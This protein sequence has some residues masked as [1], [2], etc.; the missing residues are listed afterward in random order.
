MPVS[1]GSIFWFEYLGNLRFFLHFRIPK[2][3]DKKNIQEGVVL[4]YTLPPNPLLS[5]TV[6]LLLTP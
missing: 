5:L 6:S 1:A 2:L 3:V 4:V